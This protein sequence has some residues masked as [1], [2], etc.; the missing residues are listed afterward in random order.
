MNSRAAA[1]LVAIGL[2]LWTCLAAA[3]TSLPEVDMTRA[4]E[5]VSAL[6]GQQVTVRLSFQ[7]GAIGGD[8]LHGLI[9]TEHIPAG[10][11]PAPDQ[12]LLDGQPVAALAETVAEGGV[13]AGCLTWRWVLE[14]PPDFAEGLAVPADTAVEVS[15]QVTIPAD[16]PPGEIAFPG[17]AWIGMIAAQADAGDH[18][19]YEDGPASII[20]EPVGDDQD[21]DGMPDDWETE[22]GLD[23]GDPADAD[24][25]LDGD[26]FTNLEEF[27]AGTDPTDETSHPELPNEPPSVT[28]S[29]DPTS[30]EAPLAVGFQA[31]ASDP[32]GAIADIAWDFGDGQAGQGEAP[33]HTYSGAGSFVAR[34]TVTDDRGATAN[35]TVSVMV[36]ES[37]EPDPD[38]TIH[39][40]CGCGSLPR[41]ANG[42]VCLGGLLLIAWLSIRRRGRP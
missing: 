31:A 26:G 3:F 37:G 25:D 38:V 13:E 34:V 28:A 20:V 23:P 15:Y 14:T 33:E 5:P 11:A 36:F 7:A 27:R 9:I 16:A 19:G 30:G 40:G 21:A 8:P 10:L 18:Y 6:P 12:V 22:H 4:F 35:A 17:A 39:G 41:G 29:A 2:G 24:Q 32:D 42:P 1:A